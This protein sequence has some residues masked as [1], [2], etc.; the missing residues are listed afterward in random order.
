VQGH[1]GS[2]QHPMTAGLIGFVTIRRVVT[3]T[4][5]II[6]SARPDAGA[7]Q[8]QVVN[9]NSLAITIGVCHVLYTY[10][11]GLAIDLNECDRRVTSLKQRERIKHERRAPQSY[12]EY[13]SPPLRIIREAPPL[14]IGQASSSNSVDLL[15]HDFGAITVVYGFPI[16]GP[17]YRLVELS[18]AFYDHEALRRAS[19]AEAEG[20]LESIRPA[21]TQ[22]HLAEAVEDYV[23]F[24]VQS[25]TPALSPAD[26]HSRF[27]LELAQVLRAE[28]AQLSEQEVNDTLACRLSFGPD[29]LAIVDWNAAILFDADADD[30][31]TVLELANAELLEMRFL[32]GQLDRA[33]ERAYQALVLQRQHRPWKL[34]RRLK[35]DLPRIARMQVDSAVLF[36]RINNALK[37]FG[38]Q[39]LARVYRL[40]SQR[41]HVNDWDA[42]ILRKIQT[43]ESI[44]QKMTDRTSSLRME[45]L[46]WIIIVLIAVSIALPFFG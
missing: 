44:Y 19:R 35:G 8:S 32:D 15:I 14:T 46:E 27:S 9:G 43:L 16:Q 36:E 30:V 22:P 33:L 20:L 39:Y 12:F 2:R 3:R 40:A 1:E 37:L 17:L 4:P 38:D 41:F 25:W 26:L 28:T 10:D 29:D 42:S 45:L 21:V 7:I 34:G 13:E 6:G 18:S 23:I 5:Q 31:R 24:E 11:L